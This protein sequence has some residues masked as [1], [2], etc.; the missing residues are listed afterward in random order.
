MLSLPSSIKMS[1]VSDQVQTLQVQ[2][3]PV[4]T[5]PDRG[6]ASFLLF[7]CVHVSLT[8]S[9]CVIFFLVF[10]FVLFVAVAIAFAIAIAVEHSAPFDTNFKIG[11]YTK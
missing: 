8:V 5:L 6:T 3:F 7:V 10:F 9:L 4:C 2:L 11:R 1:T